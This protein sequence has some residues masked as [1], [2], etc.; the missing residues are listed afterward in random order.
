MKSRECSSDDYLQRMGEKLE[1]L[2]RCIQEWKDT[3][4]LTVIEA[5]NVK[6][7]GRVP[8]EHTVVQRQAKLRIVG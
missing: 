6:C 4:H 8:S 5:D 2:H 3:S 7:R 1:E